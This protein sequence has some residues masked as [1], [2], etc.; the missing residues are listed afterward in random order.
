MVVLFPTTHKY[1]PWNKADRFLFCTTSD[2]ANWSHRE[3]LVRN[4]HT[5]SSNLGGTNEK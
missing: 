1:L 2:R 3:E 4:D 5:L